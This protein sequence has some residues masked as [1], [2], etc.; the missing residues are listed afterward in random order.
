MPGR[1]THQANR[2]AGVGLAEHHPRR[3]GLDHRMDRLQDLSGSSLHMRRIHQTASALLPLNPTNKT[4]NDQR[5]AIDMN[6]ANTMQTVVSER[7]RGPP[8][9]RSALSK[10][11]ADQVPGDFEDLMTIMN[12]AIN[13]PTWLSSSPND[14]PSLD[15]TITNPQPVIIYMSPP[16]GGTP[17]PRPDTESASA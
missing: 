4:K 7:H 1:F 11:V 17:T 2:A 9:E 8:P 10:A 6:R 13:Q 15:D 14:P 16:P 3:P 5:L 12:A